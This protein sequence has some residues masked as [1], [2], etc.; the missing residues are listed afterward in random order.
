MA[1]TTAEFFDAL[2]ARGHDPLI[3][4]VTGTI[5]FDVKDNGKTQRWRVAITKGDIEVSRSNAAADCVVTA[6]RKTLEGVLN[7]KVNPF[8]AS[9]RGIVGVEGDTELGVLFQR[10]LREQS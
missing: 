6:D 5:R 7:G 4:K 8:A 1:Q 2:A 3:E 9:L 10:V